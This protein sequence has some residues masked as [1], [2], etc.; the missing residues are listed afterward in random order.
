MLEPAHYEQLLE[1]F[2][3]L[4]GVTSQLDKGCMYICIF[5]WFNLKEDNSEKLE[6]EEVCGT[7]FC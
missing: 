5:F 2:G 1:V 3:L 4:G 7:L 6:L